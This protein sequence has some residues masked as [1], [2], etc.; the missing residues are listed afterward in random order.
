VSITVASGSYSAT[1]VVP[2]GQCTGPLLVPSGTATV[3]ETAPFPYGLT[4]VTTIPSAALISTNLAAS[5]ATVAVTA[6]SD[7]SV[8]TLVHLVNSTKLGYVKVCKTLTSNSGDIITAGK[9]TFVFDVSSAISSGSVSV[10]VPSTEQAACA[11]YKDELPL[12]TKVTVTERGFANTTL[13]NVQVL[14]ASQD[15]GTAAP[16]ARLT[17]GPNQDGVTTASFTNRAN[18]TIEI[19]KNIDD[20]NWHR[21]W[22][23]YSKDEYNGSPY[24]GTPF[25]FSVNGGAPIT[26]KAGYCSAPLSV[27]AGTAT[28]EEL[29]TPNFSLVGFTAVGPDGKTRLVSAGTDNPITVNVPWGGVG[30]ETLVTATN[31]VNTGQVKVCKMLDDKT[32]VGKSF[33]FETTFSVG[34]GW[35]DSYLTLTPTD[36]GP[37]GEV[38]GWLSAPLPVIN[39]HGDPIT[40][41]VTECASPFGVD[42]NGMPIVEPTS[43]TYDGN[44]TFVESLS[45]GPTVTPGPAATDPDADGSYHLSADIGQGVN[46][47][48]FTNS[49]VL[50]P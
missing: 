46:V 49:L 4:K 44:G 42:S 26:V 45:Y 10:V 14:P 33:K 1:Q 36:N 41:T 35:Y 8:E 31:Q 13:T 16:T 9:S 50:D 7:S 23:K 12:G 32:P 18:G 38:C 2:V 6:S 28:V 22:S 48:T 30:N 34:N 11:L 40:V 3:T 39:W 19:C 47:I 29:A 15:A 20:S 17:V 37:A 21:S 43:I 27:P 25:Q 5:S 24:D